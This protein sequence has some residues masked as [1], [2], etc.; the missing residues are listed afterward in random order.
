M[1]RMSSRIPTSTLNHAVF[2]HLTPHSCTAN[3]KESSGAS[4]MAIT[5]VPGLEDSLHF[6]IH[7]VFLQY[8]ILVKKWRGRLL[9]PY[10]FLEMRI[11]SGGKLFSEGIGRSYIYGQ[12]IN[13]DGSFWHEIGH[14]LQ[15]I[16]QFTYISGPAILL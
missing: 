5:G 13:C 14:T 12:V 1:G 9:T 7:A 8:R 4:H 15:H 10:I 16:F 11:S 2:D 3:T 6:S